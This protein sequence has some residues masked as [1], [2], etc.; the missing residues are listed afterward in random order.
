MANVPVIIRETVHGAYSLTLVDKLFAQREILLDGAIDRA[1]AMDTINQLRILAEEDN[2]P[3][4]LLINSPGGDVVSGF[5]IHRFLL[6]PVSSFKRLEPLHK[7][8]FI[9]LA[10]A[11]PVAHCGGIV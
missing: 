3:I 7:A 2:T 4:T 9:R 5:A 6:P 11:A 10:A 1:K 8:F